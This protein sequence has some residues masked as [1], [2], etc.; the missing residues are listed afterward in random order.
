MPAEAK[1][2]G[3]DG[4]LVEPDW[5]PFTLEELRG[6]LR[7]YPAV[8][9]LKQVLTVSPR[10]FSAA[11]VVAADIGR[12]FIKRHHVTVRSVEGLREEHRFMAH[13]R[14][15]GVAA[16]RVFDARSG[17][18]AIK[19]GE[20]IYEVHDTPTGLDLYE[21]AISWTPFRSEGHAHSAGKALARLHI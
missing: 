11:S 4:T 13:L 17:E 1:T 18:T 10:P 5:P 21:D 14:T 8:G 12:V 15:N 16:P 6:L 3:L 9:K 20:W 19:L 7:Y 2:H